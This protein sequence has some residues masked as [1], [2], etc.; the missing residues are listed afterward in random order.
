MRG[1]AVNEHETYLA[2]S[3]PFLAIV[4]KTLISS[5]AASLYLSTFLMI[6]KAE[7]SFLQFNLGLGDGPQ[8]PDVNVPRQILKFERWQLWVLVKL[9][10]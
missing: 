10:T 8:I 2:P 4:F 6:F 9:V 5:L 1:G 7:T 3:P